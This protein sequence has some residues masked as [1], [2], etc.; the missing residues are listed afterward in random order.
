MRAERNYEGKRWV[1]YDR[2]FR[3]EALAR[4]DLNWSVTDPRLYNEAFTGWARAI[5]R[6]SY[7]LQDARCPQEPQLPRVRLVLGPIRLA[8]SDSAAY[9]ALPPLRAE[10]I[11]R[12]LPPLQRR[13]MQASQVQIPARLPGPPRLGRLPTEQGQGRRAEPSPCWNRRLATRPARR[14]KLNSAH[15][16]DLRRGRSHHGLPKRCLVSWT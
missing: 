15:A 14:A 8:S 9:T 4:R 16:T 1:S 13:A 5:A 6:C 10:A 3:R 12:H 7:C 11:A 2:Q